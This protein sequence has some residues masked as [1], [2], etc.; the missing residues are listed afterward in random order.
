MHTPAKRRCPT[1][2]IRD[3]LDGS[4]VDSEDEGYMNTR[5]SH[6]DFR[7]RFSSA[8]MS[9]QKKSSKSWAT[10]CI[11]DPLKDLGLGLDTDTNLY[12]WAFEADVYGA[13]ELEPV[14][15]APKRKQRRT[16]RTVRY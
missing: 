10:R 3:T 4:N 15:D 1:R 16:L 7:G 2:H 14:K 13:P 11:W 8:T 12:D 5:E 6:S 9:P